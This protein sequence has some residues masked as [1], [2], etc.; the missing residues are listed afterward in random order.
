MTSTK[1]CVEPRLIV[2]KRPF[3]L[4]IFMPL[5]Y[6]YISLLK[7]RGINRHHEKITVNICCLVT[8]LMPFIYSF[9]NRENGFLQVYLELFAEKSKVETNS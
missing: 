7:L 6:N 1:Q 9:N 4:K 2:L 8:A 3:K 5:I